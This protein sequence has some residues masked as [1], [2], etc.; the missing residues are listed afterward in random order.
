MLPQPEIVDT[1]SSYLSFSSKVPTKRWPIQSNH[2]DRIQFVHPKRIHRRSLRS[3]DLTQKSSAFEI[4]TANRAPSRSAA[5]SSCL[6]IK[7]CHCLNPLRL[8]LT[9][10]RTM[11]WYWGRPEGTHTD[12]IN[13]E[14][15]LTLTSGLIRALPFQGPFYRSPSTLNWLLREH[16]VHGLTPNH[17]LNLRSKVKTTGASSS[18]E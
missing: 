7:N 3:K 4:A 14:N 17:L 16:S 13:H 6:Q 2:V 8:T 5:F 15:L 1:G 12:F 9:S 10:I 11:A 18:L